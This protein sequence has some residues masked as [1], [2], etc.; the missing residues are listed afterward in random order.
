MTT[1]S[2]YFSNNSQPFCMMRPPFWQSYSIVEAILKDPKFWQMAGKNSI[3]SIQ[4]SAGDQY[5]KNTVLITTEN[6]KSIT[7]TLSPIWIGQYRDC[8]NFKIDYEGEKSGDE[9]SEIDPQIYL[10]LKQ[11]ESEKKGY[12]ILQITCQNNR[13]EFTTLYNR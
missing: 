4:L 2:I 9:T 7:A 10:L 1:E 13:W 6:G 11:L 12:Q 5:N 8:C 3:E